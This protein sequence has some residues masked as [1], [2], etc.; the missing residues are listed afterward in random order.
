MFFNNSPEPAA[1]IGGPIILLFLVALMTLRSFRQAFLAQRIDVLQW[2][3]PLSIM[4]AD[5]SGLVWETSD[6]SER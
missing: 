2:F 3:C 4:L 1:S 5:C 6:E